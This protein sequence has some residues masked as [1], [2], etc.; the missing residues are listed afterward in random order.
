MEIDE[1]NKEGFLPVSWRMTLP[2]K[3]IDSADNLIKYIL[4]KIRNNNVI[5]LRGDCRHTLEALPEL[6]SVIYSKGYTFHTLN[7]YLMNRY[8]QA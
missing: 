7:D 3:N 6:I 1:I 4:K 2:S 8:Y 5:P